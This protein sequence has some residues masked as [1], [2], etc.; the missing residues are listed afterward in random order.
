MRNAIAA[1]ALMCGA[2]VAACAA[3]A[4]PSAT[5]PATQPA[6]EIAALIAQ[7]GDEDFRVRELAAEKLRAIGQ[8]ALPA[9]RRASSEGDPEIQTRAAELVKDIDGTRQRERAEAARAE[10]QMPAR[11]NLG[12]GVVRI[13]V[14][15]QGNSRVQV[16]QQVVNGRRT[17]EATAEEQGRTVHIVETD[18]AVTVTV[19]DRNDNGAET[20]RR[21]EAASPQE[22]KKKHP[23]AH[24]LYEKYLGRNLQNVRVRVEVQ[25]DELTE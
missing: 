15:A 11:V 16:R 7:L 13:Q 2:V 17:G 4:E 23:E 5:R 12:P 8:P 14:A 24:E 25:G 10:R 21:Y 18:E 22:L 6:A 3:A 1:I 9:L 20:S 19:T